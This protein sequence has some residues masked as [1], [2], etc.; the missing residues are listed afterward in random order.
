MKKTLFFFALTMLLLSAT[1]LQAQLGFHAGYAPQTF[2]VSGVTA[3]GTTTL[4]RLSHGF[5]G[6][7]HYGCPIVGKLGFTAALQIRLNSANVSTDETITQD[8][9]FLA[10]LPLLLNFGFSLG[11]DLTLGVFAGPLLSYGIS[12]TQKVTDAKNF[13]VLES[14]NRYGTSEPAYA[15]KRF[16]AGATGGLFFKF[17]SY[18]LYGGYRMGFNDLDKIPD[19]TTKPRGFFV[20]LGF[21]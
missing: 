2:A 21:N 17:R 18:M 7:V 8:W 15:L 11:H 10:D 3:D 5:F 16:E 6:G 14:H 9:Q 19:G 12:N 1:R 4:P 13:E 20:G